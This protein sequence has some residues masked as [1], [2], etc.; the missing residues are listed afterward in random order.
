[1]FEPMTKLDLPALIEILDRV[2][3]R[4][5][6]GQQTEQGCQQQPAH[7]LPLSLLFRGSQLCVGWE[8]FV[9]LRHSA[10]LAHLF[11]PKRVDAR[12]L[13]LVFDLVAALLDAKRDCALRAGLVVPDERRLIAVSG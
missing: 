4:R 5:P 13:I 7:V 12:I 3:E 9:H 8:I 11:E 6:A 10:V 1:M 2:S